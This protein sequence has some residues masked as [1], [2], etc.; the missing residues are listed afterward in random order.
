MQMM[1]IHGKRMQPPLD[2]RLDLMS[3]IKASIFAWWNGDKQDFPS[4]SFS[5]SRFSWLPD[6]HRMRQTVS[7]TLTMEQVPDSDA[8]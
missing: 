4:I 6:P 7:F 5:A 8:Q 1:F 2:I 3:Q